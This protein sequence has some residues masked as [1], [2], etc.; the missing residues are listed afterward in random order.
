MI[1]SKRDTERHL[2]IRDRQRNRDTKMKKREI[3]IE[4]ESLGRETM[5]DR[6][7]DKHIESD[8]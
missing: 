1:N 4:T 7:R 8:T 6:E 3:A 2:N 5:R